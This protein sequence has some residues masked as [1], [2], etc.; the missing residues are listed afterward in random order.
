MQAQ[1][2]PCLD[3]AAG[4]N[5][6]AAAKHGVVAALTVDGGRLAV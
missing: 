6:Y 2:A 1:I 5:A 4:M 3:E